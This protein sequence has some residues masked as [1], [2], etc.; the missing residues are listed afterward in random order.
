MADLNPIVHRRLRTE[1]RKARDGA[2]LT[3]QEVADRLDWSLSKIIRVEAG[4]VHLT[5]TD[6]RVLL[7]LNGLA[8]ARVDELTEM[9]RRART[10]MWWDAYKGSLSKQDLAFFGYEFAA[11]YVLQFQPLI[12]PGLL[13]APE[14]TRQILSIFLGEEERDRLELLT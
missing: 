9:A 12:V 1:L 6:L 14:Y 2:G 8:P 13:Q 11:S 10:G 4:N 7:Q 5:T 3:Q